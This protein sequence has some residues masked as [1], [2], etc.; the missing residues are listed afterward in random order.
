MNFL[1]QAKATQTQSLLSKVPEVTLYF[2]IVKVLTT[3]MGESTSDY[4]VYHFNPYL[5]VI[6]GA[7]GFAVALVI[8]FRARRYVAWIYWL[9]VVTVSIF[10]TMAA[11]VVHIVLGVPYVAS[12]C[13]FALSLAILFI[14][15][16]RV[17]GTLSIHS[18]YTPRREFFY[19]AVVLATFALGTATGD[20]T[21]MSLHL[22]Y[23]G[24][25]LL[26]TGL[27]LLPGLLFWA[28]G[29]NGIAAFWST[30][31]MTRPFGAS[32]ADWMGKPHAAHDLGYGSGV[33]SL[34][35]TALII[36]FVGYL[37]MSKKDSPA[38][39]KLSDDNEPDSID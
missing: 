5:A 23:L 2:W 32:F 31:V 15:W 26:F 9:L 3:A 6:L 34:A 4:L 30:Y 33:V 11:D 28:R 19:W 36:I 16:Q 10:G 18:I 1:N 21:A 29:L 22:G 13:F 25:G 12:V 35:L 38:A 24:S 39:G 8:Q 27:F 37:S 17:E 7:F 14:L 20:W